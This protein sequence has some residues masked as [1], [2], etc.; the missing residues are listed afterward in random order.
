[1]NCHIERRKLVKRG[2]FDLVTG[3]LTISDESEVVEPCG[4]PYF[5]SDEQKCCSQCARRWESDGNR[6]TERGRQQL[7]ELGVPA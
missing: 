6:L 4:V 3:E 7:R 1:M 2:T 5:K